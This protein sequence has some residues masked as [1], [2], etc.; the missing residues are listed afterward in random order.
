[1]GADI[2]EV[3]RGIG[4]DKRIGQKFLRAGIGYGGSCFPKD[5]AAFQSVARACGSRWNLLEEVSKINQEQIDRFLQKVRKAVGTLKGKRIAALGLA[6]KG[7]TDDIRE[8]PAINVIQGLL[9][10]GCK[11]ACFDPAAMGKA[12]E[13]LGKSVIYARDAYA[14]ADNADALLILT[15]WKEFAA[16]DLKRLCRL[17]AVPLVLDGRNL[18]SPETMSQAGLTYYSVGRSNGKK[19]ALD[20]A[21]QD[22]ALQLRPTFGD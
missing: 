20:F 6:F 19:R 1:L 18:F 12:K 9:A 10:E 8:S 22:G 16:L 17:L 11:I 4:S 2:E 13:V 5:V 21:M 7:G 15:E 3:R 14:A